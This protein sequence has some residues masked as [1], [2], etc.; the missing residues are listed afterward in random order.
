MC[1]D[2]AGHERRAREGDR[3]RVSRR[4]NL[5]TRTDCLDPFAAHENDPTVVWCGV[6]AVPDPIRNEEHRRTS[7]GSPTATS[8]L[9]RCEG[10]C[11]RHENRYERTYTHE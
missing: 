11:N 7:R 10:R 5:R 9:C 6:A 2:E 1:L 8:S 3:G 4:G